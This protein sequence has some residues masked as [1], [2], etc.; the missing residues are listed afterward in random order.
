MAVYTAIDDPEA[1][2]QTKIYTGTGSSAART[3]DGDTDMQPDMVWIKNRDGTEQHVIFDAVRGV[4]KYLTPN[5]EAAE[6]TTA[7]TLTAFGSDGFTEGGH[8]IT[9]G[10]SATYVAWCWKESATA[11]FDIVLYTGTGSTATPSHS[12]SAVPHVM[13]VKR[14]NTSEGWQIYHHK[15]TAAPETDVLTLDTSAATSDESNRWNDTAPTSS[16]FTVEDHVTVNAADDTY[17]NYLWTEKQGFSKF[18]S[19]TGNGSSTEGAFIYTGFR[20]AYLVV[21]RT[22]STNVWS[23]YDNKRNTFNIMSSE[24][25][26]NDNKAD[27]ANSR[28]DLLSNG[29][30][31]KTGGGANNTSGGTYVYMAFAEAPFVNSNGV[32]CNAR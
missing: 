10:S 21:K 18:G 19:Y 4:Q 15:N 27:Q 20:P 26:L 1:Y 28:F 6:A 12:L 32:P 11:G 9:G 30:Q 29:F 22:D 17:V 24:Q 16:V 31:N 8:G 13:I 7:T 25:E 14:R 23:C 3:F 2:F 5:T